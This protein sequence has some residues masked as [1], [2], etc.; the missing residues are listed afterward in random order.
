MK[1]LLLVFVALVIATAPAVAD[2]CRADCER[3]RQPECP[4]HQQTPHS[5]A[6]DHAIA[7]RIINRAHLDVTPPILAAVASATSAITSPY[8]STEF[9]SV[10]PQHAPPFLSPRILVLRI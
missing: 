1:R 4:L 8:V 9:A 6:H 3:A 10:T 7:Q 2:L 5:C